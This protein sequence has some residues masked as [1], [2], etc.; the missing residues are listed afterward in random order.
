MKSHHTQEELDE[1]RQAFDGP[2]RLGLISDIVLS[3]HEKDK[4]TIVNHEELVNFFSSAGLIGIVELLKTFPFTDELINYEFGSHSIDLYDVASGP[5]SFK[6]ATTMV[7]L[8]IGDKKK[9]ISPSVWM[10]YLMRGF[11]RLSPIQKI[12]FNGVCADFA[13]MNN[14]FTSGNYE[15]VELSDALKP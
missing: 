15:T 11:D 5:F 12:G 2:G 9:E 8:K 13:K 1:M 14:A 7:Y 10:S 3:G 4:V 6:N